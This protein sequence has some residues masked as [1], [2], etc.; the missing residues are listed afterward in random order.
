VS[1]L[2]RIFAVPALIAVVSGVGLVSA[3]VDD[4]PGDWTSWAALAAPLA[5]VAYAWARRR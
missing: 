1:G 2:L 5:A 4:G 3:L